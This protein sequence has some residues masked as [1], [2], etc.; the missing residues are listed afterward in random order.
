M[1]KPLRLMTLLFLL[2]TSIG[3]LYSTTPTE[4]FSRD[5]C[6]DVT[7]L[8]GTHSITVGGVYAPW[9]RILY[10]KDN[11]QT[12]YDVCN[13]NCGNPQTISNLSAGLYIVRIEQS[14]GGSKNYCVKE[15]AARVT[16]KAPDYCKDISVTG[17]IEKITVSGVNAP[18]HR[19][20]YRKDGSSIYYTICDDNC[21]DPQT[22]TGISAG[23]YIVKI[24]QSSGGGKDFCSK[25]IAVHVKGKAKDYCKGVSAVGGVEEIIVTGVKAP[26]NRIQYRKDGYYDY[27]S[28]CNDNCANP[29]GASGIAAGKYIVRIEQSDGGDKNYCV[30]EIAVHVKGK[31]KDYCKNVSAVGGVEEITVSGVHAPWNRI[32]YRKDG[33][34]DYYDICNDNCANPQG[35]SGI[36]AG[37][38]IVRIEQSGG[39]HKDYCVK[40]IV[41]IVTKKAIDY[42]KNISVLGGVEKITVSGVH[43][44][45]NR[46]QYRAEGSAHYKDVCD[47]FCGNPEVISGLKAGRYIVKIEQSSGHDNYCV[48]EIAAIVTKKGVDYCSGVS[49]IAYTGQIEITGIHAPWNR[50]LLNGPSTHYK[51][52]AVCNDNC[53]D[54]RYPVLVISN[55]KRGNYTVIVEQSSGGDRDYCKVEEI[56]FVKKHRHGKVIADNNTDMSA[57]L[58]NPTQQLTQE[59]ANTLNLTDQ[60]FTKSTELISDNA[61]LNVNH[62]L[63]NEAIT[64]FPNPAQSELNIT[65]SNYVGQQADLVV[66]NQVGAIVDRRTIAALPDSPLNINVSTYT[67]GLY[68]LRVQVAGGEFVTKKFMVQK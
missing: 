20:Q 38:Y 12:Y 15:I 22:L 46:I 34:Y 57:N 49:I 54:P 65:L 7:V 32:Q 19:I 37:R 3:F 41:V 2:M 4:N 27:Y 62:N 42:C 8:G 45:W 17:G 48:K 59:V 55:L 5:Y 47:D 28:I 11:S 43:A 58:Y 33:K 60:E 64:L 31:A 40:E 16:K 18:W 29:Q 67:N 24:E 9:H 21:N 68:F 10:R 25:E 6:K 51:T 50:V 66:M 26:W 30:K 39:G 36:A 14:S 35:A 1:K 13:D 23:S 53:Y 56:H 61:D 44:P 52:V 63:D